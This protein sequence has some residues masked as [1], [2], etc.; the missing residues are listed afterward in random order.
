M[1]VCVRDDGAGIP[2]EKHSRVF[3]PF[4][5][6]GQEASAIEGT[7]I[8]LAITKRLAE[9]MGGRVGFHS[10]PGQGSTFWIDLPASAD[11]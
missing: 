2:E 1:R 9:V 8:G 3:E 6:A 5:R 11:N 7:G 4:E 10:V